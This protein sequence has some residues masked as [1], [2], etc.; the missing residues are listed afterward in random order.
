MSSQTL[1]EYMYKYM[2]LLLVV[3]EELFASHYYDVPEVSNSAESDTVS[4]IVV[5]FDPE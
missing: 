2:V 3:L 5:G 1:R 4:I